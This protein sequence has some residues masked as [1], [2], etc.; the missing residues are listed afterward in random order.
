MTAPVRSVG[1]EFKAS[2]V[3]EVQAAARAA[4]R[5]VADAA[6]GTSAASTRSIGLAADSAREKW[7]MAGREISKTF[8]TFGSSGAVTGRELRQLATVGG[9]MAVMFSPIGPIASAIALLTLGIVAMFKRARDEQSETQR[10]FLK[11]LGD[12]AS[13]ADYA[14]LQGNAGKMWRGNFNTKTMKFEGGVDTLGAQERALKGRGANVFDLGAPGALKEFYGQTVTNPLD[15]KEMSVKDLLSQY[16]QTIA[17]LQTPLAAPRGPRGAITVTENLSKD[18]DAAKKAREAELKHIGMEFGAS[19]AR[20]PLGPE[21]IAA[22]DRIAANLGLT[23]PVIKSMLPTQEQ[24]DKE[25]GKTFKDLDNWAIDKLPGIAAELSA[26]MHPIGT[27]IADGI[28][29]SLAS[30]LQEGLG[31]ALSGDLGGG[32]KAATSAILRG[33]GDMF[34]AI[35]TKA[36][37]M[38]QMMITFRT[39]L[40]ANPW[41]AAAVA[42]AMMAAAAAMGGRAG[43]GGSSGGYAAT[44]AASSV[45]S[46]ASGDSVTRLLWGAD[47]SALAAGL[48]PRSA[49]N[50]TV[51]GP[52]D[53]TAQRAIQELLKN[54]NRRGG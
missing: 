4:Q 17:V 1:V 31:R 29:S 21:H 37:M 25:L 28:C 34:A 54:A 6:N 15:G 32:V 48:T 16:R 24:M 8:A 33:L 41:A 35:A 52:N 7:G 11:G 47:S 18:A 44:S 13:A 23:S 26:Q 10:Q 53:P 30:G 5:A 40:T 12:M 2:G 20:V 27:A 9:E 39:W 45:A 49:T 50:I 46:A 22:V 42:V 43:G 38:S 14:G 19:R 51:I 36:L 3:P